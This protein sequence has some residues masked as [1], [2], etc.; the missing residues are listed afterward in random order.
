MVNTSVSGRRNELKVVGSS[1]TLIAFAVFAEP[2]RNFVSFFCIVLCIV[3]HIDFTEI[4]ITRTRQNVG[5][6]TGC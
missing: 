1:P 2:Y 5:R 6:R 4:Q 3:F